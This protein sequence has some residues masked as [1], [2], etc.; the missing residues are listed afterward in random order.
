MLKGHFKASP[1]RPPGIIYCKHSR[2]QPL[3]VPSGIT[4]KDEDEP[5]EGS[6][7][8]KQKLA[9]GAHG[10]CIGNVLY[11]SSVAI[12]QGSLDSWLLNWEQW[13][14]HSEPE[15]RA[16]IESLCTMLS[17]F[18]GTLSQELNVWEKEPQASASLTQQI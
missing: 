6:S 9:T 1:G 18:C 17:H 16:S 11:R 8:E 4:I 10:P 7:P 3:N 2:V 14:G 12:L 5:V 15:G 13:Q